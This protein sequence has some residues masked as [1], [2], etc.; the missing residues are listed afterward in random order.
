[1]GKKCVLS[2]TV[3]FNNILLISHTLVLMDVILKKKKKKDI[4]AQIPVPGQ[5]T[6]TV[7]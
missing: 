2:Y 4:F 1:M 5:E 3:Q 6:A 7:P